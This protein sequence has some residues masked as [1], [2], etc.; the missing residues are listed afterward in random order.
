MHWVLM[1][2]IGSQLTAINF[3]DYESCVNA[4]EKIKKSE[5]IRI[6]YVCVER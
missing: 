2:I 4:G 6:N 3:N 5:I 1:M